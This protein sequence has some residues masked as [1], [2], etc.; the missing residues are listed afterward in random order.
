[1]NRI[2]KISRSVIVVVLLSF[3]CNSALCQESDISIQKS[4]STHTILKSLESDRLI[5]KIR[6]SQDRRIDS[7]LRKHIS[8]NDSVGI[9]GW[10]I[11]IYHGRD[12]KLAQD[13]GALFS[14]SFPDLELA[15]VVDYEAPDFK[16]LV[17]AFRT[18]EA[19]YR[20]H[21]QIL[22]LPEFEFSYLVHAAIKAGE[23]K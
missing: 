10:K 3:L 22:I 21:Q 4:D 23:L 13:A 9:Q 12:I 6:I 2:A 20:L 16:T 11:M 8:Y 19:A 1:M 15:S 17:G 18:K 7:L 5:G 14:S